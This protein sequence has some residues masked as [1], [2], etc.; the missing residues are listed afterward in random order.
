MA[1]LSVYGGK[2]LERTLAELPLKL[3][4]KVLSKA[5]RKAGNVVKDEARRRV[6]VDTG[7]LR[8]AL[9]VRAIK[10]KMTRRTGRTGVLVGASDK[11][12]TGKQFYGSFIEFGY[13]RGARKSRNKEAQAKIEDRPFIE[14]RP[15]LGPAFDAKKGE[16]E[17]IFRYEIRTNLVKVAKEK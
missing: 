13:H 7:A 6:P 8:K 9:K 1:F 4:K 3:Q 11:D 10:A 16:A 15:Y 14:P 5:A 12:F 2:E 17:R